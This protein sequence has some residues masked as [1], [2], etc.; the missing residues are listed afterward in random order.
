MA[1][2]AK[3]APAYPAEIARATRFS[4]HLFRGPPKNSHNISPLAE[5]PALAQALLLPMT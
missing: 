4:R 3:I 1:P 5:A 2:A